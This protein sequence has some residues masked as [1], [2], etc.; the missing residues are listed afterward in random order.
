MKI[1]VAAFTL[2]LG[3]LIPANASELTLACHVTTQR[4]SPDPRFLK[5]D[6]VTI[7]VERQ[8]IEIAAS[9]TNDYW[10]YSNK[11]YNEKLDWVDKLVI[12]RFKDEVILASGIRAS[13]I[14]SMIYQPR[15]RKL[16]FGSKNDKEDWSISYN[17]R[18]I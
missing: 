16:N 3:G 15:E 1:S 10:T 9:S 7:D 6:R 4:N 2:L 12:H 14:F 8:K 13:A 17:C 18:R 11:E 5:V